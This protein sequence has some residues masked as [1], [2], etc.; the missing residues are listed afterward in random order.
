M[1]GLYKHAQANGLQVSDQVPARP[2]F[3]K[4]SYTC[5]EGRAHTAI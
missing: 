3:N 5:I 4:E 1:L 2:S